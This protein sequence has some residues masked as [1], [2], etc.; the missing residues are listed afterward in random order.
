MVV[1]V[2]YCSSWDQECLFMDKVE[3]DCYDKMLELVEMLVEVL[4]KVVL[5]LKEEQVEEFGIFMV[6]NCDVFVCVFKNQLDVFNELFE[7]NVVDE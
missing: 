4:Q 5:L 3:V 1:E 6:K 2:V 7:E